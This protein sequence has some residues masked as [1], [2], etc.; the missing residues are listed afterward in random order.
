MHC[1][2]IDRITLSEISLTEK[3]TKAFASITDHLQKCPACLK[4]FQEIQHLTRS[5]QDEL[6][7]KRPTL[8][9]SFEKDLFYEIDHLP[10]PPTNPLDQLDPDAPAPAAETSLSPVFEETS[11]E[12]PPSDL[13]DSASK[14][15]IEKPTPSPPPVIRATVPAQRVLPTPPTQQTPPTPPPNASPPSPPQKTA[16]SRTPARPSSTS[17]DPVKKPLRSAQKSYPVKTLTIVGLITI[18]FFAYLFQRFTAYLDRTISNPPSKSLE[19]AKPPSILPLLVLSPEEIDGTLLHTPSGQRDRNLGT[20]IPMHPGDEIS[21][22]ENSRVVLFA[23]KIGNLILESNTRLKMDS[24]PNVF[25]IQLLSGQIFIQALERGSFFHF[26]IGSVR[27]HPCDATGFLSLDHIHVLKKSMRVETPEQTVE[28]SGGNSCTWKEDHIEL[29]PLS[30]ETSFTEFITSW[31]N[32]STSQT[33]SLNPSTRAAQTPPLDIPDGWIHFEIVSSPSSEQD[34]HFV[35]EESYRGGW[36]TRDSW[37]VLATSE[38]SPSRRFILRSLGP[39]DTGQTSYRIRCL[40][41][42]RILSV[43]E[44]HRP[45]LLSPSSIQLETNS[46]DPSTW[47]ITGSSLQESP[48]GLLASLPEGSSSTRLAPYPD[49]FHFETY[50][51]ALRVLVANRGRLA[52]SLGTSKGSRRYR[53]VIEKQKNRYLHQLIRLENDQKKLVWET[54]DSPPSPQSNTPISLSFHLDSHRILIQRGG[55][56]LGEISEPDFVTAHPSLHLERGPL[57]LEALRIFSYSNR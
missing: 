22:G 31:P 26:A 17:A 51:I 48:D 7:Q 32:S 15:P 5:I 4:Q 35:L 21:T 54:T 55:H 36:I 33:I 46:P 49:K 57:T 34:T 53:Y 20:S 28:I 1:Q 29:T 2:S 50:Q 45:V 12:S 39:T 42:S 6:N 18:L 37:K 27:I 10:S 23:P 19:L 44:V 47:E 52:L 30:P 9:E 3:S 8:D 38:T 43:K 25:R 14:A 41:G 56:F 40:D 11:D 16:V 24:D 13:K